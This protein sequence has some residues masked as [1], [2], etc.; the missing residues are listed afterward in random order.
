MPPRRFLP[1]LLASVALGT[2]VVACS[3]DDGPAPQLVATTTTGGDTTS[4]PPVDVP[5]GELRL[6]EIGSV[7]FPTAM[8]ADPATGVLYVAE[9][10]GRVLR[11]DA[12]TGE[13]EVVLDISAEVAS[14]GERGLLGLTFDPSGEHL[15]VD[16]TNSDGNTRVDE[17]SWSDGAVEAG[18]RREVLAQDQ[19]FR[20]HNGGDIHFGPDGYLYVSLGDGGAG[21]DPL[22]TGQDPTDLLGSL[23]R[24]DPTPSG[25]EAYTVPADNPFVDGGGRPEVWLFGVRNPWRFSFDLDT[26]DLWIGD[27][28]QSAVEEIDY[29][30][31]VDG[32]DAGRGANLGWAAME[33]SS[34]FGGDEPAD[35]VGPVHDY[36]RDGGNCSVTGGYVY[37]GSSIPGLDGR[38]LY[39]DFCVGELRTL[40][41]DAA[42]Q[43]TDESLGLSVG[44]NTLSS[45]GQDLDGEVYVLSL[46][47][48][49]VYRLEPA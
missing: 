5:I 19:P 33:G 35:H 16:Y 27:V 34:I 42:G 24:I 47:D 45:F 25:D 49:K 28:G 48:N 29:L 12:G 1:L 3:D 43:A 23:L 40:R 17:F 14:G 39:G 13:T 46:G 7:D 6:T 15:Y 36:G 37:R 30:P 8:A 22:G 20:N 32:V 44:A 10:Q 4:A 18:S 26:G 21:G 41:L 9:Q 2:L 31:A 38:Y 11:L